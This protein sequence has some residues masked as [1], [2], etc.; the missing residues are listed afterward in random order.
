MSPLVRRLTSLIMADR[1]RGTKESWLG[2]EQSASSEELD[3][4]WRQDLEPHEVPDAGYREAEKLIDEA[5]A[6]GGDHLVDLDFRGFQLEILPPA[7]QELGPRLRSLDCS[8]VLD[9]KEPLKRTFKRLS[10]QLE[11]PQH[12]EAFTNLENV[13]FSKCGLTT[14]PEEISQLRK[15]TH[16]NLQKNFFTSVPEP[17]F[18]LSSLR[19]LDLSANPLRSLPDDLSGLG[20]LTQLRLGST[21]LSSLPEAIGELRHLEI[22]L[23]ASN[24]LETLPP[25]FAELQH[26]RILDLHN[27]QIETLP[28]EITR[29]GGLSVLDLSK[30]KLQ[31]LPEAFGQLPKLTKLRLGSNRLEDLPASFPSLSRL[32]EL[33]LGGNSLGSLPPGVC[34]FGELTH[35]TLGGNSISELPEDFLQLQ[36][37]THLYLGGNHLKRLP[38]GFDTLSRLNLLDLGK[39]QLGAIPDHSLFLPTNLTDLTLANN[40][41]DRFPES[42]LGMEEL[43]SLDLAG[44]QVENLP[45]SICR[46]KDLKI[47]RLERNR[48]RALPEDFGQLS[49]LTSL[50]LHSNRLKTVPRS[51]FDLHNV[52]IQSKANDL[53][54]ISEHYP[55]EGIDLVNTMIRGLDLHDNEISDLP[56][57][58]EC[59]PH[60]RELNLSE[61]H[62][63]TF[64]KTLSKSASLWMLFLQKNKI[65]EIP[66]NLGGLKE[67]RELSLGDNDLRSFPEPLCDLS[68]LWN[69]NLEQNKIR[70]IP[71]SLRGLQ[72]LRH[73]HLSDNDI[74][75]FPEPLLDLSCLEVLSLTEN[76]IPEIPATINKLR[77]LRWLFISENQLSSIPSSLSELPK[78][79][80]LILSGNEL[81]IF[82]DAI[83]SLR[84][85]RLLWLDYN[86]ISEIPHQL[87]DHP[88][89]KDLRVEGNPLPDDF[90][91]ALLIG[92]D[93]A[94]R[95]L[96]ERKTL[97]W[98]GKVI[99]IGEGSVGKTKL[100]RALSG[101]PL[102]RPEMTHGLERRDFT[103]EDPRSGES[104]HCHGWDFGGQVGYRPTQ[105][106]FF[107]G[108][109]IYLV[110][111]SPRI[112]RSQEELRSWMDQVRSAAG[113]HVRFLIVGTHAD[114]PT[115]DR[116]LPSSEELRSIYG[117]SLGDEAI[118]DVG[119]PDQDEG[120][121]TGVEK[122]KSRI[123][124]I[125]IG[126]RFFHQEVISDWIPLRHEINQ[127]KTTHYRWSEFVILANGLSLESEE[128]VR[129]FCE[130]HDKLGLLIYRPTER[131]AEDIV[132]TRPE[133][134]TWAIHRVTTDPRVLALHG[135]VAQQLVSDILREYEPEEGVSYPANTHEALLELMADCLVCYPIRD[136]EGNEPRWLFT[137]SISEDRPSEMDTIWP[138]TV[139][140]G[141]RERATIYRF[142]TV[143]EDGKPNQYFLDLELKGVIYKLIVLLHQYSLGWESGDPS[144]NLHWKRGLVIQAP[145]GVGRA[146]IELKE[147]SSPQGGEMW[148]DLWITARGL[149]PAEVIGE[150]KKPINELL[151]ALL[152]NS[153]PKRQA[154][155]GQ[156]CLDE[157][158][159]QKGQF[160][161]AMIREERQAG[162]KV[163]TCTTCNHRLPIDD[164][165]LTPEYGLAMEE[166]EELLLR[167]IVHRDAERI[168]EHTRI[169][170][171]TVQREVV[172]N[173]RVMVEGFNEVSNSI[174]SLTGLA[175]DVIDELRGAQQ[176][177]SSQV[178]GL[179][180]FLNDEARHG[181]RLIE[182]RELPWKLLSNVKL[183]TIKYE[184]VLHCE[185]CGLSV[186]AL[187]AILN[188][189]SR[190][191]RGRYEVTLTRKW[192]ADA[193]PYLQ[194]L[195]RIVHTVMTGAANFYPTIEKAGSESEIALLLTDVRGQSMA[196]VE[197]LGRINL[198][199]QRIDGP[200]I[201][202]L[203][204]FLQR[205]GAKADGYGGLTKVRIVQKGENNGKIRW[206]HPMFLDTEDPETGELIYEADRGGS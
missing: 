36:N 71:A 157:D 141:I 83:L 5:L 198:D 192:L 1:K 75:S 85:L 158:R 8:Y 80:Q 43:S 166:S 170:Q 89:L 20:K 35:L 188:P 6:S 147:S 174:A 94:F 17:V 29:I 165:L 91:A 37:L 181:P 146:V 113:G 88:H 95:W 163:V 63:T 66:A 102:D 120:E 98:E 153:Q 194:L 200:T 46:L 175:R 184:A 167:D 152:G 132:I 9:P 84:N 130:H 168:I 30:N 54:A 135:F 110:V 109:A 93:E 138:S 108:S 97:E 11:L 105:Q 48:I 205:S 28:T 22:L 172:F 112:N 114:I 90:L 122:L 77:N 79:G 190:K 128:K 164:L 21:N 64:P 150:V 187:G 74:R 40:G 191:K 12:W 127:G 134:L 183:A 13:N 118:F 119:L 180:R 107:S 126:E 145:E 15:I 133:W 101:A 69:L 10:C 189:T 144:R 57:D 169:G 129:A 162:N 161:W 159:A 86:Q 50:G 7:I 124:E 76:R 137:M 136:P 203:H 23:L 201:R 38:P 100:L 99:L 155:C 143:R 53:P 59:H 173:R 61:N 70:E 140:K 19:Q 206:I 56:E 115:L 103:I 176:E 14:L 32:L 24:Q 47:L 16:L 182:I 49:N 3:L 148:T 78:L 154:W 34:R 156:L 73:L 204:E 92:I 151:A 18:R 186:D 4:P 68:C 178:E 177:I 199:H 106:L 72:E 121:V 111:W 171:E 58:L 87:A 123:A 193:A 197:T 62:F 196:G 149:E 55:Q 52:H 131:A 44:N 160:D 139:P 25:E 26:L 39:N 27:N 202:K 96:R 51:I 116:S 117:N 45:E 81:T 42:I 31:A 185:H 179:A 125:A 60:I 41:L 82:P 67:L 104:I 65:Q 2:L 195:S 33:D 142:A